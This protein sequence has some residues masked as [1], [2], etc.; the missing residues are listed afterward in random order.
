MI[1]LSISEEGQPPRLV[2]FNKTTISVGRAAE[3]DLVLGGKGVSGQH[4]RIVQV[5]GGYR[6]ED[7][8]S[9]NGTYVNRKR[10]AGTQ[11]VATADDV[12]I[13]MY[14]LKF[15][16]D[17][18]PATGS[19]AARGPVTGAMPTAGG[20]TPSGAL[21]AVSGPYPAH[22]GPV[23]VTSA[24][25][26]VTTGPSPTVPQQAMSGTSTAVPATTR[27]ASAQTTTTPPP[28]SGVF[29]DAAWAREWDRLDKLARDWIAR[30]RDRGMLLRG[31]KLEHARRWLAQSRGRGRPPKREH[32]EFIAASAR[33][34]Q[35]RILRNVTLG[36][37]VLGAVVVAAVVV[38]PRERRE[39]QRGSARVALPT[40]APPQTP[41]DPSER[42][43]GS[44]EAAQAAERLIQDD[45]V[46]AGRIALEALRRVPESGDVD[47]RGCWA[48]RVLRN[49]LA[50]A[51][52][53]P[54][55]DHGG[56]V[57][58]V[59]IAPD[60]SMAATVEDGPENRAVRLWDLDRTAAAVPHMLR[61]HGSAVKLL[62]FSEDGR[63]LVSVD[64]EIVKLWDVGSKERPPP[65]TELAVRELGI[66]SMSMSADGR[67]LLIG[68]RTGKAKLFDLTAPASAPG[69][70]TG[71]ASG[72]VAVELARNGAQAITA[73]ED[74]TARIW[75]FAG[76]V[77]TGR[78]VVLEG[79]M[80]SVLDAALSRDGKWALTG[81]AD[82]MAMLWSATSA[83]PAKSVR[84][85]ATHSDQVTHVGFSPNSRFAVTAGR[86]HAVA[87]WKLWVAEPEAAA[88]SD[89]RG[90][91][92]LT[93]LHLR[94]PAS[95]TGG[96]P[97][98]AITARGDGF[99]RVTDLDKLDAVS[100][101]V[102]IEA[103]KG[104][105]QALDVD[106]ASQ[107]VITGGADGRAQILDLG[108]A[109]PGGPSLVARGHA[110]QVLD[111]AI[112]PG[113]ARILTGSAD[114][115]ARLW[116]ATLPSRLHEIARLGPHKGR[117]RAVAVSPKGTHGASAGEDHIVRL[118]E[119]GA[120]D[121]SKAT[122]E[123]VG[124]TADINDLE[125]SPNG[126]WL[127]SISADKSARAWD[128]RG[129]ETM[130]FVLPHRDE[131]TK[132]A[133]GERWLVTGSIGQLNLWD[134]NLSDPSAGTVPLKGHEKDITAVAIA[135]GGRAAASADRSGRVHLWDITAP[136]PTKINLRGHEESV[137]ALAFSPDAEGRWLATAGA[138]QTVRLWKITSKHPDENAIT[139]TGHT[140]GV[141]ALAWSPDG[142]WLYSA[143]ND[144]SVRAWPVAEKSPGD[145]VMVLH[146]HSTV[147]KALAVDRTGDFLVTASY[148]GSARL[149]P[150]RPERLLQVGCLRLGRSLAKA[151]WSQYFGGEHEPACGER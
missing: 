106:A 125:F 31:K 91:E 116:D 114:G 151:E 51:R 121:P 107:W 144:G 74:G 9:T 53:R 141:G 93:A 110:A 26:P 92:P 81:G 58:V 54:L 38:I 126:A 78:S 71:H 149:W 27:P 90:T 70:L 98:L 97:Q 69:V 35:L 134:L 13:A 135:P 56:P 2:T 147:V 138:D 49:A 73:S 7:L 20:Y 10:V 44:N 150:L 102:Q 16:D 145:H 113:G 96:G 129:Q 72:I 62:Q 120:S 29:D 47:A 22:S 99:V 130:S 122:R 50:Q 32:K 65:S 108:E 52:G 133:L 39:M 112:V 109:V 40:D 76:G 119:L 45:P 118:W 64:D 25:H 95:G 11:S 148:D 67:W 46:A 12:V 19:F 43:R 115:S 111:L 66:T 85:L 117:V 15:L 142:L 68:A 30:R 128:M 143:S 82:N 100:E 136:D 89:A 63:T 33:A 101:G 41:I 28:A 132:L 146:G 131:V 59:A 86:D 77:P 36:G 83:A 88:Q 57:V 84:V 79:H 4:C 34:T 37:L 17:V 18:R 75:R 139:L 124:H 61:G 48:E 55:P 103:H 137:E 14:T 140:G 6:I 87:R 23:P 24:P 104:S 1:R 94:G 42:M 21:P 105:V 5:P 127:V 80:G 3:C 123:L 60:G 8:G